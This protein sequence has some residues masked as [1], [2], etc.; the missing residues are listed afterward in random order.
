MILS[1]VQ[2]KTIRMMNVGDYL[3]FGGIVVGDKNRYEVHRVTELEYK[4]AVFALMICLNS[5]Y[6]QSPE[7]VIAYIEIH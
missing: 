7:E 5:D 3:T 1:N 2:K 4:V 6:V